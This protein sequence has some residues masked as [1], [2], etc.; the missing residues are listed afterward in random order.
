M[1]GCEEAC[2]DVLRSGTGRSEG[3]GIEETGGKGGGKVSG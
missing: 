1:L 2:N 3:S